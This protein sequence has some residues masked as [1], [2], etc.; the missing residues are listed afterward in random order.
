MTADP[1]TVHLVGSVPLEDTE[2][3]FVRVGEAL[4][5]WLSRIVDGETG[6]RSSWV[7]FVRAILQKH[8]AFEEDPDVAP[9]RFVQWDG[10]LINEWP[11]LRLR[12]GVD[13]DTVSFETGYADDALR[14]FAI[15]DRAQE[16]GQIPEGVRYQACCGTPLAIAYL[17]VSPNSRGGFVEAYS[18]H[19][20]GEVER[21]AA[22]IPHERLAYQWDVAPEVLMWEGY[23]DQP[24]DYQEEILSSLARMSEAVPQSIEMGYHL[25]Y[26]SPADEHLV[27]PKD[28]GVLVEMTNG[29]VERS[30]RRVDWMHMPVPVDRRD[31]AYFEPL[32][33][34]RL[35][36]E[37]A[38]YL[39]C[40]HPGE[41]AGNAERL[42][43]A[44]G[45]AR[46]DGIG[47]ECGWGR[48]DP[49]KLDRILAA[50]RALVAD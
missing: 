16:A 3:V 8:P 27:Q 14:S 38:L 5:P 24:A 32:S 48:G 15:F 10:K 19:L 50:H 42:A 33:R 28:M 12:E 13:P 25:C 2:T 29:I 43:Q 4:G 17:W 40:V 41:E 39:G 44:R 7:G 11:M 26:G 49:A 46:I 21:I 35:P 6:R 18:R 34:L 23:F 20:A 47:S 22:A 1:L 9:F 31:A 30:A 37:T 45:Y 36:P